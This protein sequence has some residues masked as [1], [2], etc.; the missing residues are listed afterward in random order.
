MMYTVQNLKKIF[1]AVFF[2]SSMTFLCTASAEAKPKTHTRVNTGL[3]ADLGSGNLLNMVV[4]YV[5]PTNSIITV[6]SIEIFDEDGNK[7]IN[8]IFPAPV[9]APFDLN[10]HDS[11]GFYLTAVSGVIRTS[12]WP[13]LGSF[14]VH[15]A[16]ASEDKTA[17]LHSFSVVLRIG[18]SGLIGLH[19]LEGIDLN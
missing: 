2:A 4:Q 5:N 13:P 9:I 3:H 11:A 7:V 10:P 15:T 6:Y 18:V 17:K 1:I 12:P 16:W 19:S 14:Q 8:P